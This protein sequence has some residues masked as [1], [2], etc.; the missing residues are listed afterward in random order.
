[1]T[2]SFSN[3]KHTMRCATKSILLF[4]FCFLLVAFQFI[5]SSFTY[6]LDDDMD[7][8]L[9]LSGM[10][11]YDSLI[12]SGEGK[13]IYLRV[14]APALT[15][16]GHHITHEYYFTFKLRQMRMDHPERFVGKTR[17][18]KQTFIDTGSE[19]EWY[20]YDDELHDVPHVAY[21]TAPTL[22]FVDWHPL[23]ITTY[24]EEGSV[25]KHLKQK[26]FKIR[27]RQNLNNISCYV[28]ENTEGEKIWISPERGFRFLRYEHKFALKVNLPRRG[29]KQGTP[30][31]VLKSA[32]YQKYG[33]AW[34]PNRTFS[35]TSFIDENGQEQLM[36][37]TEIEAQNF[38][39]NHVIP[40]E[41][42]I[43]EIPQNANIYVHDLRKRM[44]KEEFLS[45]YDLEWVKR[46]H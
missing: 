27:D 42:F 6:S 36:V 38:R 4:V 9:I 10:Q 12:K 22:E 1:M 30:L 44:S 39:V 37:K 19:G 35:Q 21:H 3:E 28:L 24:W 41:T 33:E 17:Y 5:F 29:L 13:V 2:L 18:P 14:Q 32:S 23:A 8:E 46:P 34:F 16:G 20:L 11:Y 43:V 45:L 15:E 25:L 31:I 40:K 7:L 26:N